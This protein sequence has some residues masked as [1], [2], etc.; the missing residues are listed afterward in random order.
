MAEPIVAVL[1]AGLSTRFGGNKLETKCLGK[2][3]GRWVLDA[4]QDAGVGP[5]IIVTG[6]KGVSFANRWWTPLVNPRPEDGLGSSLAIAARHAIAAD[7]STLMVLLADMPLI[8]P[9]FVKVLAMSA[10]PAAMY[11]PDGHLGVPALLDRELIDMAAQLSGDKGL[12]PLLQGATPM[13]GESLLRDVDTPEDLAEVE[14]FLTI[15]SL[16]HGPGSAFPL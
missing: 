12:G 2:P 3:V 15:R 8:F 14:R 9:T 5:G 7:A 16:G 1:A 11:Y 10:A 6:P 4:V 13:A